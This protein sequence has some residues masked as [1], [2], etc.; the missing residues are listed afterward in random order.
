VNFADRCRPPWL[1][2][3]IA[4]VVAVCVLVSVIGFGLLRFEL[5]TS[6]PPPPVA[7]SLGADDIERAD[8]DPDSSPAAHK[9]VGS[10]ARSRA[11]PPRLRS[12]PPSSYSVS[13]PTLWY[14]LGAFCRRVV[15]TSVAGQEL[16][17]Q[18]CI[19]RR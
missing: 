8:L 2:S 11:L 5:A 18:F 15:S 14:R 7:V 1:R 19:A 17:T 12:L 16:L 10:V 13:V 6:A 3:I 9:A 4:I